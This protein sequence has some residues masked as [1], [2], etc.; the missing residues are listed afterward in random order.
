MKFQS[1]DILENRNGTQIVVV[2]ANHSTQEYHYKYLNASDPQFQEMFCHKS[3]DI[4][5]YWTLTKRT[6]PISAA[7]NLIIVD[8]PFEGLNKFQS[9]S[10][11]NR[12]GQKC[13]HDISTYEGFTETYKYCKKCDEKFKV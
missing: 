6:L 10:R 11:L 13:I 7:Q 12:S 4:E 5:Q 3:D 1:N 9:R 8:E 2:H